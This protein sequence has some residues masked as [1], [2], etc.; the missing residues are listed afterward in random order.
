VA[1]ELAPGEARPWVLSVSVWVASIVITLLFWA[2]LPA[3]W[4]EEETTDY[5][6]FYEPVAHALVEGRGLV[7]QDGSFATRYPPGYPALV[8]GVFAVAHGLHLP[9][10]TVMTCFILMSFGFTSVLLYQLARAIWGARAA[11]AAAAVWTTYPFALWLTRQPNSEV[12]FMVVFFGALLLCWRTL[13][14]RPRHWPSYFVVG[15]LLGGAML[16]RPIA[17]GVGF[18]VAGLLWLGARQM[19][20]RPRLLAVALL[21][22]GNFLAILP[23]EAWM[24]AKTGQLVPLC[25]GGAPSLRDG[26]T[27]AVNKKGFRQGIAVPPDVR[28]LM[29]EMQEQCDT[30]TSFGAVASAVKDQWQKRPM[31]VVKLYALKLARSWYGTDSQR[32]ETPILLIQ[33]V[34]V[35]MLLWSSRVAWKRGG[36][37]KQLLISVWLIVFYFWGMNL[38]SLPILRYTVPVVGLA[39]VLVPALI[40]RPPEKLRA[41]KPSPAPALACSNP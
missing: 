25:T 23:W 3:K 15:L 41:V 6:A 9:E 34:Y 7:R 12:P 14:N 35:G 26:L 19:D 29:Q 30:L 38:I 21:L 17:I 24:Y 1:S 16:I 28:E 39:F 18:V 2:V 5:V 8:A 33:L 20:W 22:A 36:A 11:L 4:Q 27:F 31:A 10:K 32:W 40:S 13:T 37:A